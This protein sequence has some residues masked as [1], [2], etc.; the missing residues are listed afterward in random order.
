LA[1]WDEDSPELEGN[2]AAV[3]LAL[4]ESAIRRD[5][6]SADRFKAWHAR[7]MEGLEVDDPAFVGRFRG[8]DGVRGIDVRVLE[9]FGSPWHRVSADVT[10]FIDR[11]QRAL[12]GLDALMPP[13][14]IPA[15]RDQL[16]AV[17]L[18]AAR[19]HA[20]WV[21]IHPFVNGNGR[22]ARMW[23][24][25]ILVRYGVPAFVRLRPRPDLPEYGEA[26]RAAL[27]R[28]EFEPTVAAFHAMYDRWEDDD[29]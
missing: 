1:S 21:E 15:T 20:R 17:I 28:G 22:T 19:A 8:E 5:V 2:L 7:T 26:G 16:D 4:G 27:C 29:G 12:D 25:W 14:G 11:V 3:L 23:A 18:L 6:A 9:C 24:N 10:R 13:G